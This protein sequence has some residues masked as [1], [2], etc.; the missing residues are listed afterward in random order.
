MVSLGVC[1]NETE[2]ESQDG[3]DEKFSAPQKENP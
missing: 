1:W 2:D 3:T